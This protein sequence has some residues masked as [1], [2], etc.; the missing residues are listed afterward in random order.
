MTKEVPV[1]SRPEFSDSII[2]SKHSVDLKKSADLRHS[3]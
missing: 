3:L 1:S 2:I